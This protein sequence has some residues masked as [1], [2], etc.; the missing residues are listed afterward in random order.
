MTSKTQPC[1]CPACMRG[2]ATIPHEKLT[3]RINSNVIVDSK[4]REYDRIEFFRM[5]GAMGGRKSRTGGFFANRE[6]ARTAGA[7]GGRIGKRK[8][9]K[10]YAKVTNE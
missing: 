8:A 7:K 9:A 3:R 5:I 4:G 1:Y 2:E 6:L 10:Y